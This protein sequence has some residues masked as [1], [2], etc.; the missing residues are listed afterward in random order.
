[1]SDFLLLFWALS[2]PFSSS[3][4]ILTFFF[5]HIPCRTS[6]IWQH[7][8]NTRWHLHC[9]LG[10]ILKQFPANLCE[11]ISLQ[12]TSGNTKNMLYFSLSCSYITTKERGTRIV[13]AILLWSL[14]CIECDPQVTI[15]C[16]YTTLNCTWGVRDS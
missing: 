9:L 16:I 13:K 3:N 1:M 10:L 5:L 7:T 8:K 14:H 6:I 2:M 4:F 12:S 11:E 15:T